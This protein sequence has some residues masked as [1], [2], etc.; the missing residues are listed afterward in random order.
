MNNT[1]SNFKNYSVGGLNKLAKEFH[2]FQTNAGFTD[3]NITQ[4]L[5]LVHSEIT[6]AFEAFR[7]DKYANLKQF[8]KNVEV[9]KNYDGNLMW[10]EQFRSLMKDT[11]EDELADALIRILAICEENNVDI[12]KHIKYKMKYNEMR[13]Y[14][15]GGKKF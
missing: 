10:K 6:E 1:Y 7:K 8:E 15:Y 11:F 9:F 3:S 14:K 2:E 13:G 5:M 12:E 4:R